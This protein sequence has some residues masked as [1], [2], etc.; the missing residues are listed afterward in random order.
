MTLRQEFEAR[1]RAKEDELQ[2]QQAIAEEQHSA[3]LAQ[4]EARFKERLH[5][6]IAMSQ[7]ARPPTRPGGESP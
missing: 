5:N 6:E 3:V 4:Q 7:S 1:L 2:A